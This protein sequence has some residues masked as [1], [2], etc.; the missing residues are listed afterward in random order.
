MVEPRESSHFEFY[1]EGSGKIKVPLKNSSL[2]MED[3]LG[4]KVIKIYASKVF[5]KFFRKP[6]IFKIIR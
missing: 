1:E 4:L 5:E 2:Y 3:R 6:K